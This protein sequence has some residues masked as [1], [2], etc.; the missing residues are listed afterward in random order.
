MTRAASLPTGQL[1]FVFTDIEGSTRLLAALG[2]RYVEIHA[3]HQALV[4]AAIARHDGV[5]VSTEGDSFF[6]VFR[7]AAQ[8]ALAAAE[9]TTAVAEHQWPEDGRVR[10]RIGIHSGTAVLGGEG[11]VGFDIHR[12]AR[13]GAAANGGQILLSGAAAALVRD[14]I[15]NVATLRDLGRHRLKDVGVEQLYRLEPV[16]LRPDERPPRTLEAGPSNLPASAHS[17][18]DRVAERHRLTELLAESRIV[19]ITGAGGMGK[20]ALALDVA[21]SVRSLF[22]DGIG[23]VDIAS[24]DDVETAAAMIG[25]G[26]R[27]PSDPGR[28]AV[29]LLV[30]QLRDREVL[31]VVETAEHL[32]QIADMLAALVR[33]C[34]RL[35]VLVTSRVALHL[36]A[37]RELRLEPLPES[38]ATELFVARAR[39]VRPAFQATNAD[40]EAISAIAERLDG[41]PLAIELAAARIRVLPPAQ[42]LDRLSKRLPVLTGGAV[43]APS[44][45]RT[46]RATVEWSYQQLTP[47]EVVLLQTLAV[48]ASDFALDAAE[49]LA[50]RVGR[51]IDPGAVLDLLDGLVDK[52]LVVARHDEASRFRLLA[53]IGEFALDELT[54]SGHVDAT[55]SA[56]LA[57]VLDTARAATEMIESFAPPDEIPLRAYEDD[58]RAALGWALETP[59]RALWALELAAAA[60][61]FWYALGRAR[62][63][64]SWI[65][66]AISA[67]PNG[68]LPVY[69][70]A[71]YWAG[72][73]ADERR[74]P[75]QAV[76]HLELSLEI[77]RELGDETA[78]TRTINSLG[79]VSRTA[80][81]LTRA[82]ELLTECLERKRAA[83]DPRI[84]S[85]ITNLAIVAVDEGHLDEALALFAEALEAD[86]RAG[87]AEPHPAVLL[88]IALVHVRLGDPAHGI[89]PALDAA[90]RFAALEDDLALAESLDVLVEAWQESQPAA[91]FALL[92][93]AD[94][95]HEAQAMPRTQPD[96]ARLRQMGEAIRAVLSPEMADSLAAQGRS[97][98]ASGVVAYADA[99]ARSE[100]VTIKENT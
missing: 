17:L 84:G 83:D 6:V 97:L 34:S 53:A 75:E 7:D 25:E 46:L 94:R 58:L 5:E 18:V 48:L 60:G 55:R 61:Q 37:E 43:D 13:I 9:M 74:Q 44:R 2:P 95:L 56:H 57:W 90:R 96:E 26:L 33:G 50:R 72:V 3:E 88:G 49:E 98:D 71:H 24:I 89:H 14:A 68:R 66:R 31:L 99:V 65:D 42:I 73:L 63:G 29:G 38:A 91:A 82:R 54:A 80:G 8:A 30:E 20:T 79:I 27:L 32:P 87:S 59:E 100:Q 28:T 23:Y 4:R 81:D 85:T 70:D 47:D 16:G 52:S 86:R 39:A 77:R 62:E 21:N 51:G 92:H 12:A 22:V 93:A 64:S 15:A 69:G 78:I 1:T 45:Q 67:A 10:I 19:T 36:Q 11:Y 41:L 40:L 76:A 35:R